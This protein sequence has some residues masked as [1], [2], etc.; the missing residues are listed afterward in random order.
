[1]KVF[2]YTLVLVAVL[3]A[4]IIFLQSMPQPVR[5]RGL[6][7]RGPMKV[8]SEAAELPTPDA[9]LAE[10]NRDALF[11]TGVELL[12]LWHLPEAIGVF[13]TVV[14]IDSMHVGAYLELVQCYSHPMISLE[15]EAARCLE[16]SFELCRKTGTDTVWASAVGSFYVADA[17]DQTIGTLK[18]L[19]KKRA[20]DDDVKLLF[21]A[22]YLDK[23][24]LARA[25]KYLGE[26]LDRD[27][28]LGRAKELLIRS[29]VAKGDFDGAD[30]IARD[31][32]STYPE[33]PHPYVLLSEILL[34]RGKVDDALEFANSAISLDPRYIPAIVCGADVHAAS[35]DLEAARVSYEKLLLFDRPMLSA[36]AMEGIAHVEFLAGRFEEASR[37][38]EEAARLAV[39][40]GSSRHGLVYAFRL[41]DYL[42]ELGRTDTAEAVRERWLTRAGD[43]PARLGQLRVLIGKGEIPVVRHGLELIKDAPAWR[44]WMTW[45]GIDYTDVYALS[46]IQEEDYAGALSLMEA[47]GFSGRSAGRR[48]YLEGFAHFENGAA[49]RAAVLLAKARAS[50]RTPEFPYH[51]DP[52]LYVQSIFYSAEAALARG[53][54]A[55][56]QR[57][58]GEFLDLWGESDWELQAV[59]RARSKLETLSAVPA[60]GG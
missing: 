5:T 16:K 56:A 50:M 36:I 52:V 45:L 24:D 21:A 10:M 7:T 26:L 18:R 33:E 49:E 14:K 53:E 48:A 41:I 30:R 54:S 11:D 44:Q 15:K 32:A 38:M 4:A 9:N 35:G 19:D 1:L 55:E 58:Y 27:P 22:A 39:S 42:C 43:I 59:S 20:D 13:E 12:D 6:K 31:L 28:S 25:E 8:K 60:P 34:L 2:F 57:Y 37:D 3:I 51:G 29:R 23:G 47:A 17:P 40:A 46:L